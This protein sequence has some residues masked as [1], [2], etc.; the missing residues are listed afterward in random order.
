MRVVPHNLVN[1]KPALKNNFTSDK[2]FEAPLTTAVPVVE[3]SYCLYIDCN[4]T[5]HCLY[6]F[7]TV[8]VQ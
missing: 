8:S 3:C 1:K 4:L 7:S 6:N 5:V 2:V